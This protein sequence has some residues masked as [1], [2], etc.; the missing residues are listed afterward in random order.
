MKKILGVLLLFVALQTAQAESG[1]RL[2][3]RYDLINNPA[4]LI[5]YRQ[6]LQALHITG[7]SATLSIVE[8]E[9]GMALNGFLGKPIPITNKL[10]TAGLI[11]CGTFDSPAI[12]K[13]KLSSSSNTAEGF[14]IQT[15]SIKGKNVI[16]I[17]GSTD[18]GVL[19]GTFHFLQQLQAHK[20]ITNIAI[21]Q[22]PAINLR[23]LNHW[24]NLDR[25]VERGYAGFSLW[26]W[27]KLPEY[28]DPRYTDYGAGPLAAS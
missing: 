15:V 12:K 8:K 4:L 9:L 18:I 26:N 22:D 17:A 13:L 16:V 5:V 20:S 6:Q 1:Y 25:T 2:W 14:I 19:Y 23:I 24:D 3:L 28:L 7:N 11:L 21:Q 27:H 10:E